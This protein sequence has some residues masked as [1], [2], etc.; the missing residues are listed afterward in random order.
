MRRTFELF[1]AEEYLRTSLSSVAALSLWH[2]PA[3]DT[4]HLET[5][6]S[7]RPGIDDHVPVLQDRRARQTPFDNRG[8]IY[9]EAKAHLCA[10]R[11]DRFIDICRLCLVDLA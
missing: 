8:V 10:G 7:E 5:A 9:I 3:F 4:C 2:S 6:R 1:R 11:F